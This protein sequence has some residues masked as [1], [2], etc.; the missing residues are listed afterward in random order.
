MTNEAKPTK[1]E[2][3]EAKA[4]RLREA[5]QERAARAAVRAEYGSASEPPRRSLLGL[6][7]AAILVVG[8][9][10]ALVASLWHSSTLSDHQHSA[11]HKAQRAEQAR[12]S[13]ARELKQAR[14]T[15]SV[16][17][18]ALGQS[19]VTAAKS[20]AVEFG[21]YDY[22]HLDAD[23]AKVAAHLTPQ[24]KTSYIASS[25]KLKPAIEQVQGVAVGTVR[26][27]GLVSATDTTA[28][29]AVFLDQKVTTS[30]SSTPRID[31][32]RLLVS[33]VKSGDSWLI[34]KLTSP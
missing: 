20:Y 1:A 27:A 2:R 11:E 24:F 10:A 18:L 7:V 9:T 5:E 8:L 22:R 32:N 6:V 19:A 28:L 21:S 34:S 3:L 13:L 16:G 23:F 25:S 33:L 14:S 12:Q 31:R 15:A 30:Q 4:A 17:N 29:V 26:A